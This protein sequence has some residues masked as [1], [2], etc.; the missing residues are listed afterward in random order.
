[1]IAKR[2]VVFKELKVLGVKPLSTSTG[3]KS[4]SQASAT[5]N[6]NVEDIKSERQM[7]SAMRM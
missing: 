1:M 3:G 6:V 7:S 5:R 4:G 2:T